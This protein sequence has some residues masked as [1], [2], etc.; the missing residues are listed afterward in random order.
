MCDLLKRSICIQDAGQIERC[1]GYLESPNLYKH[2]IYAS[3]SKS[4][5]NGQAQ[6]QSCTETITLD[7]LLY[8][9]MQDDLTLVDQLKLAHRIAT[10]VL[11]FHSTPWLSDRWHLQD[12]SLFGIRDEVT[13]DALRTLHLRSIFPEGSSQASVVPIEQMDIS[14]PEVGAVISAQEAQLRY[15][16][17]N[18]T[19]FCLG[20]A[21]LELGHW[22][23]LQD[24]R[25][26]EDIDDIVTAR[27]LAA[28]GR[29]PLG[30]TKLRSIVRKCLQCDFGF[31][32]DLSKTELQSAVYSDVVCELEAMISVMT[33]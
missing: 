33:L 20:V 22:R 29:P 30:S 16:I 25:R 10:A 15:R 13:Q 2:T 27:R 8:K 23:T 11:Q 7:R 18:V 31:G 9:F 14:K 24:L 5:R 21:L 4:P 6:I 17:S 32:D 12:L 1:I 28:S 26:A 19:L 3:D